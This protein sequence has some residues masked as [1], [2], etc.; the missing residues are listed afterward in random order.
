MYRADFHLEKILLAYGFIETTSNRNKIKGKKSFR[1][2]K[3]SKKEIYFD[4]IHIIIWNSIHQ[5]DQ[6]YSM[7][8][9]ELRVL[10]LYFKLSLSDFKEIDLNGHFNFKKALESI[11]SIKKEYEQL[12]R[13]DCQK[14]HR[15][16]LK[17]IIDLYDNIKI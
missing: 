13:F 9:S 7:T 4:Y 5:Q 12:L 14:P 6:T 8:E 3:T 10:L 2:S 11:E 15:D 17:R 16:K 1:L